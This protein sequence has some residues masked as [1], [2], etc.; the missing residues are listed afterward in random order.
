MVSIG[1]FCGLRF[2]KRLFLEIIHKRATTHTGKKTLIIGAGNTGDMIVR[3]MKRQGYRDYCPIGMLDINKNKA[4]TYI[5]GLK[6]LGTTDKLN[7]VVSRYKVEAIV[8]AIPSLNY[9]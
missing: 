8:I 4:G 1:L 9:K 7:D 3:D 6:V 5:H 2:S